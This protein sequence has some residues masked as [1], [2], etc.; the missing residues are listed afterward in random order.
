M[1]R[2]AISPLAMA[3]LIVICVFV[4][5]P[6]VFQERASNALAEW[7]YDYQTLIGGLFA[8][9]AA[10]VTVV[11][12]RASDYDNDR[13]HEDLMALSFRSDYLRLDRAFTRVP[14][15]KRQ[16]QKLE[17]PEVGLSKK[18]SL[19]EA[20][21]KLSKAIPQ[22]ER[23]QDIG[24]SYRRLLV[25]DDVAKCVDL[26]D[27]RMKGA[28]EEAGSATASL[29]ADVARVVNASGVLDPEHHK[30]GT[31]MFMNQRQ[32][33]FDVVADEEL[34]ARSF[35]YFTGAA[36]EFCDQAE[37]LLDYYQ[38]SAAHPVATALE[39]KDIDVHVGHKGDWLG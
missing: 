29:L 36:V 16:L 20:C 34:W 39:A 17:M 13:R 26:F 27:G 28:Y 22:F 31:P 14:L 2:P 18:D 3:I 1:K 23:L 35:K 5:V 6:I 4:F 11:H 21:G 7:V 38:R 24:Q 33:A 10:Y 19:A 30:F 32:Q 25:S 37:R 15:L 9:A 8:I 12:M